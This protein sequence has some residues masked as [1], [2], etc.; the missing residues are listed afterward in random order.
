MMRELGIYSIHVLSQARIE[1]FVNAIPSNV[2]KV[3][4]HLNEQNQNFNFPKL[5]K[6]EL[7]NHQYLLEMPYEEMANAFQRD[8]LLKLEKAEQAD[9]LPTSSLK[10]EKIAEFYLAHS[11]DKNKQA[12]A[13]ASA[14]RI[15]KREGSRSDGSSF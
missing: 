8:F 10:P 7:S 13:H 1:A 9:L 5:D 3:E 14:C 11:K 15:F 6:V 4:I 12:N 2:S